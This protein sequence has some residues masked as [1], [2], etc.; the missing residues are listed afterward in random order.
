M[1]PGK[2][3]TPIADNS[4]QEFKHLKD[5]L[6]R[7]PT[8]NNPDSKRPFFLLT[9]ASKGGSK[10]QGMIAWGVMQKG[11]RPNQWNPIM[12]GGRSVR[13]HEENYPINQL[14]QAAIVEGYKDNYHLLFGRETY[15]YCDN[16]PSIEK[17]AKPE[18]SFLGIL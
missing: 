2:K 1:V 5:S 16:K 3:K 18:K 7:V 14:E 11:G 4:L 9:D 6:F 12:F 13:S 15:I 10:F 17:A 8:L